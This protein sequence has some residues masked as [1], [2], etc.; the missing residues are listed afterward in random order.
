MY[1]V[2][3]QCH[4]SQTVLPLRES[5]EWSC[6]VRGYHNTLYMW[7]VDRKRESCILLLL[8]V[9]TAPTTAYSIQD[10]V[11]RPPSLPTAV[12]L[13][14]SWTTYIT[15]KMQMGP[16][17]SL[18][19]TRGEAVRCTG[20]TAT[21]CMT[22]RTCWAPP[23]GLGPTS[24]RQLARPAAP[25]PGGQTAVLLSRHRIDNSPARMFRCPTLIM[26]RRLR[27]FTMS[28]P[29]SV[30]QRRSPEGGEATGARPIGNHNVHSEPFHYDVVAAGL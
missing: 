18:A 26:G 19:R 21:H 5:A 10:G 9:S 28:I 25:T 17:Q 22:R 1:S 20:H 30:A 29:W 24:D 12:K 27:P 3:V 6:E 2:S 8:P 7:W 15:R 4:C 14:S 23:H 11:L 13:H 16:M